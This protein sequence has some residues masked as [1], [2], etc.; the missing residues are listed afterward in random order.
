LQVSNLGQLGSGAGTITLSGGLNAVNGTLLLATSSTGS[1]A[2]PLSFGGRQGSAINVPHIQNVSGNNTFTGA[3]TLTSGGNDYVLQSDSGSLTVQSAISTAAIGT[4]GNFG[5]RRFDLQGAGSGALNGV[6]TDVADTTPGEDTTGNQIAI[7]KSGSGTWTLGASSTLHGQLTINDSGKL[8]IGAGKTVSFAGGL[9]LNSV[10]A[11]SITPHI[12]FGAT[13]AD[14]GS[15]LS[16]AGATWGATDTI[17]KID[18]WTYGAGLN[19]DHLI[20]TGSQLDSTLL[21]TQVQFADFKVGAVMVTH[22]TAARSL[23]E[24]MPNV[25]DVNQ[26]GSINAA[27]ISALMSGLTNISAFQTARTATSP[28]GVF[29]ASDA[30]FLLDV[31]GDGIDTNTDIQAEISLI[32]TIAAGGTGVTNPVPEPTSFVLLALGGL[33]MAAIRFRRSKTTRGQRV[34]NA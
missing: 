17:L 12:S 3:V 15:T 7:T 5:V 18:N 6:L 25:G 28:S 9:S 13:G 31:N 1:T 34:R 23:G 2:N 20:D 21:K 33:T 30:K 32:A 26:D 11:A 8:A 22:A 4:G 14:T 10:N 16:V 29:T 27:D 19:G 24:I